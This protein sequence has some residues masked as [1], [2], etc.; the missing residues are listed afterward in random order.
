MNK[1]RYARGYV[2]ARLSSLALLGQL[3]EET[4]ELGKAALKL[5]RVLMNEN[6]TP[7][8]MEEALVALIE[9]IAD[10]ICAMEIVMQ[11]LDIS[12]GEDVEPIIE[13]KAE[14]WADR[15]WERYEA[16]HADREEVPNETD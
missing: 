4:A 11:K 1:Y 10:V 9:E 12:L 15:V 14:R 2:A 13:A 16:S 5:Q 6:P 8:T 7:V 3:A